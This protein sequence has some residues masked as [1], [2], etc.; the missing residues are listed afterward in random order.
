MENIIKSVL[1]TEDEIEEKVKELGK[2]IMED[3]KGKDLILVGILK[4][5]VIFMSDLARN[6][7]MPIGMDFMAVSSYGRSST[8]TGEVRI[9]KDLD[10]SVENKDVLIVED[11]IDTG[12]TL[13]YL[14]DN[15]KKRGAASVKVCTLLDKP[16]RRKVDVSVDYL[17]FAIPDEFV[18][19]Y[20]LDY[21]EI[22]RNLPYVAA[23]KEEVYS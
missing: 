9:I 20:G 22:G 21:S 19:G 23:L 13:A 2:Q 14:T 15:L 3:Y 16:E 1:V 11:I 17:G 8:S 7:K 18:V 12:Y 5:A 6:I 10:F 4:G